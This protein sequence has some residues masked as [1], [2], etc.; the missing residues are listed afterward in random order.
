[1]KKNI[2]LFYKSLLSVG[3]AER[4]L[5]QE[6]NYFK[7]RGRNVQILVFK[8][9][10]NALLVGDIDESA[11]YQLGSKS[12]MSSIIDFVILGFKNRNDIFL[13]ASG[14]IEIFIVSIVTRIKYSLHIHHPSS[15]SVNETDKYS[16]FQLSRFRALVNSN[17]GARVFS[18][19]KNN[20]RFMEHIKINLRSIL[21]IMS[22]KYSKNVIVLSEFAKWEKKL[23][24]NIDPIVIRGGAASLEYPSERDYMQKKKQI[25]EKRSIIDG[26]KVV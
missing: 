25:S 9:S 4:L 6:Y 2:F 14:H 12:W 26:I 24:Y 11:I 7:S 5:F 19:I 3:G 18:D 22:I 16:I 20:L 15:M 1:M 23:M 8:Y 13:C 21:S 10:E 17:Y